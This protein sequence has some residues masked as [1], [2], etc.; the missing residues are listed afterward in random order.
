MSRSPV[1][2]LTLR[3]RIWLHLDDPTSSKSAKVTAFVVIGAIILST[4]AFVIQTLPQFVFS[5]DPVWIFIE[6]ATISGVF[7][8]SPL[9]RPASCI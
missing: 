2:P 5:T 8:A 6:W 1:H 3:Q 4:A 7:G 9:S